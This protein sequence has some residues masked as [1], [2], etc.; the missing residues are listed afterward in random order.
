MPLYFQVVR[1]TSATMSGIMLLPIAVGLIVT[2]ISSGFIT[3][4]IGYYTPTMVLTSI[5]TPIAAGLLSTLTQHSGIWKVVFYQAL[6]GSG[7][8]IGFQG[9]QVAVQTVLSKQDAPI[10]IAIIQVAQGIG[11]AIFVAAAQS[12]FLNRLNHH[13]RS[14]DGAGVDT[15][16]TDN[17]GGGNRPQQ[18]EIRSSY[19]QALTDVFYLPTALYCLS[20]IG[21]LGMEPRSVKS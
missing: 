18:Q 16:P 21:A 20:L 6:L 17:T 8:G 3:S 4:H 15:L 14:R 9:P 13:L 11:P 2:V 10:G 19:D 1:G 7:T 12:L 5:T